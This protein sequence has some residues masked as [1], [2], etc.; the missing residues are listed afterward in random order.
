MYHRVGRLPRSADPYPGLTIQ[1]RVFGAQMDWLHAQ[2][3]HAISEQDLFDALEWGRPLPPRPVLITFDDGYRDV[4]YD[5]EPILHRLHMPA[6]TFVI[7]D[8]VS[9]RDPSFL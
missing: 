3:F 8:R 9:S 7:T 6:T 5:A 1:Q 4:L 2:G